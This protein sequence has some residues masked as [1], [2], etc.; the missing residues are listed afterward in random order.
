MSNFNTEILG[1]KNFYSRTLKAIDAKIKFQ[2]DEEEYL[3]NFRKEYFQ[4]KKEKQLKFKKNQQHENILIGLRKLEKEVT[5][6]TEEKYKH[7]TLSTAI[8]RI[9]SLPKLK[10]G[11]E[12]NKKE[13][14]YNLIQFEK[15]WKEQY[16]N[17]IKYNK[18]SKNIKLNF[19]G[20][21][22]T[23][24]FDKNYDKFRQHLEE[25]KE[26]NTRFERIKKNNL[27]V[28]NK[29]KIHR[30]IKLRYMDQREYR[31]NFSVIE[32][33]QPE[34]KLDSKSTR[35]FLKNINPFTAPNISAFKSRNNKKKRNDI[36]KKIISSLSDIRNSLNNKSH[37]SKSQENIIMD[38]KKRILQKNMAS[39]AVNLKVKK[40]E[41]SFRVN[42]NKKLLFVTQKNSKLNNN[43]SKSNSN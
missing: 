35:L 2:Q 36:K 37:L 11:I 31:P 41:T 5:K 18:K 20:I 43:T 6:N 24:I 8:N 21:Y 4:K 17:D 29:L 25:S 30:Q 38:N 23:D 16:M 9:I 32:K 3:D 33:H 34:V 12:N 14:K 28:S 19:D 42:K 10:K 22:Y 13:N 1:A 15:V 7:I 39:S 27:K 40:Y 26:K